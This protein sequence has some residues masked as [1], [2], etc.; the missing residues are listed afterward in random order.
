MLLDGLLDRPNVGSWPLY[1]RALF[2]RGRLLYWLALERGGSNEEAAGRR[3][4][5]T[6]YERHADDPILAMYAGEQVEQADECDQL[7]PAPGAPVWSRMQLEAIC[8]MRS[9]THWWVEERQSETGEFGGKLG[10]DVELLREWYPLILWGDSTTLRGYRRLADGV[11]S[12][13]KIEDGFARKVSDVEHASEF[14]ADTAPAMA[15]FTL[16]PAYVDRLRPSARHFENLWTGITPKG[17]RFFRS[18]WFSSSEIETEPPKNRDVNYNTRAAKALR[19]LAHVTG[20]EHV[21]SLLHEWS[22]SWA[23]AA[24]STDKGKP[25]GIPPAS[26]RFPDEAINGDEPTWYQPKM[27]WNYFRWAHDAG[28]QILDQLLHTYVLT[29]DESLLEPL[30]ASIELVQ[31]HGREADDAE[32]GSPAWAARHLQTSSEFWSVVESWR[33][34]TGDDRYDDLIVRH[35][36]PYLRFRLTGDEAYLERGLE[37][38]LA[39]LRHNVPL[40]TSEVLHTDRVYIPGGDHLQAMIAGGGMGWS[41]YIA[42]SWSGT[43]SLF[44]AL[45]AETGPDRLRVEIYSH[46]RDSSSVGMHVHGL[47]PGNYRLNRQVGGEHGGS[48]IALQGSDQTADASQPD[49]PDRRQKGDASQAAFRDRGGRGNETQV[50]IRERGQRI[51][52]RLPPRERTVLTLEASPSIAEPRDIAKRVADHLIEETTLRLVPEL[53]RAEQDGSYAVD[54]SETLGPAEG[55]VYYAR[56]VIQI[57][58]AVTHPLAIGVSHSAGALRLTIDGETIYMDRDDDPASFQHL[59]YGIVRLERTIRVSLPPGDHDVLLKMAPAGEVARVLVGIVDAETGIAA[60]GASMH[61]PYF[62]D[63]EH[64]AFLMIGPFEGGI[65]A[66]HPPDSSAVFMGVDYAGLGGQ[67]VRWDKPRVHVVSALSERL[68]YSDWRYFT[69]TFL[70]ALRAVSNTFEGLDY[71]DYVDRHLDFFLEHRDA[72]LR[73]RE[74]YGL[75]E[76]AFGHYFRFSLLDDVGMQAVPFVER[77][78]RGE[79]TDADRA[80]VDRII[81]HILNESGRLEDGTFARLNPDSL[82]VWADDLF[83]GTVVLIRA[84]EVLDRPAL[85]DEA[86][87]QTIR[88]H[89]RLHDPESGLYWHGWFDRTQTHSSSKWG[90]ANGWTMMA[91][92]ELLQALPEDHPLYDRVLDAFQS[93]ASALL[94]AQSKDGRWHQVLD[95]PDTYLETSATAMFVRAFAEGVR[96]GWLPSEG[97]RQAAERGWDALARQVRESGAVEGIVRGTPIFYSDREYEEHVTRLNDPRGLGAVLYA[98]VAM[99]RLHRDASD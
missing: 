96:R 77:I 73:E 74:A 87:E 31:K 24:E 72:V 56:S 8:R 16:D 3:D 5:T 92:T 10:D 30:Y 95:N 44:T 2:E 32:A 12:S 84:S 11:W 90:R 20:D 15:L 70:D 7:Q 63:N 4:L 53:A 88:I 33:L 48:Q 42:V 86:A 17:H 46:G 55:G 58:S 39:T 68:E 91:K 50:V 19:F 14:I 89:E 82:T 75:R 60:P 1:E 67:R 52:L 61:A 23:D 40:R 35:G 29:G 98:A 49:P 9:E 85:L 6:L 25:R 81:D 79:G 99:E 54:F 59:D 47:A 65:G 94:R 57:D 27:Y 43:D 76:S 28:S 71:T 62:E 34:H 26:I 78:E 36:T 51:D 13:D 22:S 41:P 97:Y 21:T 18:A 37:K 66:A 38:L 69:G 83:M 45:V 93:H 80:L 64:F